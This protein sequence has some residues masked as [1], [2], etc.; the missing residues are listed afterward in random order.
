MDNK[1]IIEIIDKLIGGIEPHGETRIDTKNLKHI[2]QY[3]EI[4]EYMIDR[5]NYISYEH[6]GAYQHSVKEIRSVAYQFMNNQ[7]EEFKDF[8]P[9]SD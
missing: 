1:T 7:H 9:D 2:I 5:I 8:E 6:R 4:A 3:K